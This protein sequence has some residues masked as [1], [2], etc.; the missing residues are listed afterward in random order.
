MKS[1]ARVRKRDGRCYE[2]ALTVMLN[3]PGAEQFTLVHGTVRSL[4]YDPPLRIGHAWIE[5]G[6]GRIYDPAADRYEPPKR[7]W[8]QARVQ[9]RYGRSDVAHLV[10]MFAHNGP[11]NDEERKRALR[12]R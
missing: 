1:L 2:L 3:E 11:W 4:S 8:K 6:D 5:L 10:A 9:H 12:R 7:W